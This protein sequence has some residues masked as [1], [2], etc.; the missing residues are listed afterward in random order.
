MTRQSTQQGVMLLEELRE[1][2]SEL[3]ALGIE[4]DGA[5]VTNYAS[6]RDVLG[7]DELRFAAVRPS[8]KV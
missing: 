5:V 4:P 3:R 7:R 1:N 8:G 2:V 6:R